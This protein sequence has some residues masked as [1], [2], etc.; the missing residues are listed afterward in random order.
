MKRLAI[1]ATALA[2]LSAPA[3]AQ[4]QTAEAGATAAMID[5]D[6]NGVGT[7]TF[8]QTASGLLHLFV[9]MT[10][11][12]AGARGFHIHETGEC[13]AND[14]FESAGGH[15]A[16]GDEEHGIHSTNGPH[17]GDLPN[18]HVGQD[19]ILKVEFFT[20]RM[21]LDEGAE[22]GLLGGDGTAVIVHAEPDDYATHPH[23]DAGDRIACGVIE[24]M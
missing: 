9:E 11:L 23:G 19:G 3:Y 1:A 21:S 13:D 15:F 4:A 14:G 16:A 5:A 17:S 12:P 8:R 6:G 24:A 18:V 10:D 7:V 22:N 20:E 2:L